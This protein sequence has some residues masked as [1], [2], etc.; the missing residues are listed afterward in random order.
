VELGI[1]L[2]LIMNYK[3][4]PSIHISGFHGYHLGEESTHCEAPLKKMPSCR[5]LG[6]S[7][8]HQSDIL[9]NY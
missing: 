8:T 9:W 7:H 6:M 3:G 2:S 1:L 4:S 5:L